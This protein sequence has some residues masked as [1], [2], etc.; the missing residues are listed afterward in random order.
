[1][2]NAACIA[3]R[4]KRILG[5]VTACSLV[6]L[7]CSGE[8]HS[9]EN[10]GITDT[11]LSDFSDGKV[12]WNPYALFVEEDF[13]A[14]V[15]VAK[16][17][18][19]VPKAIFE[20]LSGKITP[21]ETILVGTGSEGE[22]DRNPGFV[23]EVSSVERVG[24]NVVLRGEHVDVTSTFV[25]PLTRTTPPPN[26]KAVGSLGL[27]TKWDDRVRLLNLGGENE[28]HVLDLRDKLGIP[29]IKTTRAGEV[30]NVAKLVY[31]YWLS[32]YVD[33]LIDMKLPIV[34]S[35]GWK[36][37]KKC[38]KFK[39]KA[40]DVSLHATAGAAARIEMSTG[41]AFNRDWQTSVPIGMGEYPL[42]C[43]V[44]CSLRPK[45]KLKCGLGWQ[46]GASFKSTE[47]KVFGQIA[48]GVKKEGEE[49]V[50][51][52]GKKSF[53]IELPSIDGDSVLPRNFSVDELTSGPPI[54]F[55]AGV[56]GFCSIIPEIDFVLG[57]DRWGAEANVTLTAGVDFKASAEGHVCGR[58]TPRALPQPG[59][60]SNVGFGGS[61]DFTITPELRGHAGLGI[62]G[63]GFY[64]DFGPFRPLGTLRPLHAE[65]ESSCP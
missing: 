50:P 13:L 30:T 53:D 38:T 15:R 21:N 5:V 8:G 62:A 9:E 10:A 64:K 6:L 44:P 60:F 29:A 52:V 43:G 39:V 17:S 26:A 20:T 59:T 54:Q 36:G 61:F 42:N 56:N 45:L 63:H 11:S 31:K 3:T 7:A 46:A 41:I 2:G 12:H 33:Y 51:Y 22:M 40:L 32:S 24:T 34:D 55:S 37:L 48:V 18:L 28:E 47:G 16:E 35:C 4:M 25:G 1:M 14:E 23:F 19:T 58:Y 57:V 27:K 65:T 49:I